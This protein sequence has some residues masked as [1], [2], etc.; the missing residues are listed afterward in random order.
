MLNS[1]LHSQT[2]SLQMAAAMQS[3]SSLQSGSYCGK[4]T[5][6]FTIKKIFKRR[7]KGYEI[8]ININKTEITLFENKFW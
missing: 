2:L 4:N 1:R 7:S 3:R 6:L 8:R 5:N